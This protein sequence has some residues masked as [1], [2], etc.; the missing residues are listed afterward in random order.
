[1]A[2]IKTVGAG[3]HHDFSTNAAIVTIG[4]V[5]IDTDARQD[6]SDVVIDVFYKAG[7]YGEDVAGAFA[8]QIKIPARRYVESLSVDEQENEITIREPLP[9]D[10]NAVEV[11]I[12]SK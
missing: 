9:L 1:M 4:T 7:T 5:E 12:W 2:M 10:S 11:T 8:A 6:D 3:P